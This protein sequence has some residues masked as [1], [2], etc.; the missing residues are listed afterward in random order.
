MLLREAVSAWASEVVA[1]V[2]SFEPFGGTH[3]DI[4]LRTCLQVEEKLLE[5]PKLKGSEPKRGTPFL[6]HN[7]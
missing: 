3:L 7:V 2:E 4:T 1:N 5:P 6:T